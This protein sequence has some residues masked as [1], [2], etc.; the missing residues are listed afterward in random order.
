MSS[1]SM[2]G[3][4]VPHWQRYPR[5][6]CRDCVTRAQDREW[7][8]VEGG[9]CWVDGRRCIAGEHRFGGVVVQLA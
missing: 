2:C 4:E 1:C 7:R 6:L 3:T 8:R 5:L 9:E